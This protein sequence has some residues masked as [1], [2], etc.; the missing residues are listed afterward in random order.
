MSNLLHI[1]RLECVDQCE[2]G[3]YVGA[4][5]AQGNGRISVVQA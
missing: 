1:S 2:T 3:D 4:E 5:Q